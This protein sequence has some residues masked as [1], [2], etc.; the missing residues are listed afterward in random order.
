MIIKSKLAKN[1]LKVRNFVE[2]FLI[3]TWEMQLW[4]KGTSK[5]NP[6]ENIES[7]TQIGRKIRKILG[8]IN[9]SSRPGPIMDWWHCD[10][11][12]YVWKIAK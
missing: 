6:I 5:K 9:L 1:L 2:L 4:T 12:I 7:C 3:D 10:T 11:L 8:V